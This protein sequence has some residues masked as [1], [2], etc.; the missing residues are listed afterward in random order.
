VTVGPPAELTA[1]A[2]AA[3]T[4]AASSATA[5]SAAPAPAGA[6]SVGASPAAGPQIYSLAI[7]ANVTGS[8]AAL[9][10]FLQQ[11]QAVQPRAVLITQ[12]TEGSGVPVTGAKASATTTLQLTMQAFVAPPAVVVAPSAAPSASPSGSH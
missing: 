9:N 3:G 10:K 7:T 4:A 2:A 5:S 6:G 11:L 1:P 8:P 12:I